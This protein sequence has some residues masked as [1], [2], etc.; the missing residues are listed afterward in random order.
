MLFNLGSPSPTTQLFWWE[1]ECWSH[2]EEELVPLDTEMGEPEGPKLSELK[3]PR[4][5]GDEPHSESGRPPR[6]TSAECE[7]KSEGDSLGSESVEGPPQEMSTELGEMKNER[8][9]S[10]TPTVS[11]RPLPSH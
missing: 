6:G 11:G 3:G 1:P 9:A 8:I 10:R 7:P 4:S 2:C 5:E